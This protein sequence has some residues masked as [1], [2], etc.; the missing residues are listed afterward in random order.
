[1]VG[2]TVSA[3]QSIEIPES[4]VPEVLYKYL[5]P[6][7]IDILESMELRFSSPSQFNDTFDSH[8]LVPRSQ[9]IQGKT[10]RILLRNRLGIFCL[11]EKTIT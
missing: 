1:M 6:E 9:G 5:P 2:V 7:R 4:P 8:Y 10:A 3:S 11:T